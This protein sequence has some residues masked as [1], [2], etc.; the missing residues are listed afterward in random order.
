MNQDVLL[1]LSE[2]F[3]SVE[4]EEEEEDEEEEGNSAT[5]TSSIEGGLQN[6][7]PLLCAENV[8]M[9][10]I[11]PALPTPPSSVYTIRPPR[12]LGG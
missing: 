10:S 4:E 12:F 2:V 9:T 8:D 7:M 3:V 11:S 1:P 6:C 5:A